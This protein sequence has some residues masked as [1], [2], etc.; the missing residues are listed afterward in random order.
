MRVEKHTLQLLRLHIPRAADPSFTAAASTEAVERLGHGVF[1]RGVEE[2]EFLPDFEPFWSGHDD[3]VGGVEDEGGVARVVDVEEVR[4][5]VEVGV[6]PALDSSIGW[7]GG[8]GAGG[9]V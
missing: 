1:S 5:E 4:V 8:G 6:D 3:E 9:E 7:G 2:G